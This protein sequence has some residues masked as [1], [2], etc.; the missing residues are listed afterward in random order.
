MT[1][2]DGILEDNQKFV[3]N[4]EGEEMSHHAQK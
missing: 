2:L 1:I 4:F 3:E